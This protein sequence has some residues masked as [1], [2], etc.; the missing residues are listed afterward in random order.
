MTM[1]NSDV[2]YFLRISWTDNG[3]A[4]QQVLDTK[5]ASMLLYNLEQKKGIKARF[6]FVE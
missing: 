4:K 3:E 2:P 1:T 5:M 6:E